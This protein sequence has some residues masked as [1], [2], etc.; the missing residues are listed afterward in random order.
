MEKSKWCDNK[1]KDDHNYE[2]IYEPSYFPF[3]SEYCWF[4]TIKE[5]DSSWYTEWGKEVIGS[6]NKLNTKWFFLLVDFLCGTITIKW[7]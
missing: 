7:S 3:W 5:W 1:L 6:W 4:K 2:M